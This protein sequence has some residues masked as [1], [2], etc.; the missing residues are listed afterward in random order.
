MA[1]EWQGDEMHSLTPSRLEKQTI[2]GGGGGVMR[3]REQWGWERWERWERDT[4]GH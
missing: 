4:Q 2:V 1:P 3:K